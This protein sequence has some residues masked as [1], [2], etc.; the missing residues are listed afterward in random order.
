MAKKSQRVRQQRKAKFSQEHILD[1]QF[2]E[3]HTQYTRNLVYAVFVL[4][5]W[6]IKVKFPSIKAS[7]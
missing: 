5:K 7:W 2:V 1:V 6:L 3:D 4:E